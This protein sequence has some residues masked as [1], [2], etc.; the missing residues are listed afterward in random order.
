MKNLIFTLLFLIYI[1]TISHLFAEINLPRVFTNNMVLQR[2]MP[3]NIWGWAEPDE[4]I[5]LTF[6]GKAF[7]TKADASGEW[8][9]K[10]PA[11]AAGGPYEMTIS[12]ENKIH[13]KNILFGDV[14][15]CSG[16]S[17]MYFRVTAAKNAYKDINE[18][19]YKNIRLFQIDKD[20]NYQPKQDLASGEWQECSPQTVR[21][22]SAVAYFFG[23]ELHKRTD[24]PIG[25]IH[26]S[27][28]G[29]VIQAWMDAETIKRFDSYWE[30][31]KE[32]E[33]TPDYFTKLEQ[34]Y[35][36]NG[37]NLLVKAIYKQDPGF[38]ADGSLSVSQFFSEND[39]QDILV[40]GYWEDSELPEYN[41]TVWYRKKI[42]LPDAF[43]S[44]DLLLD[45]GWIDDYDFTFFNGKRIGETFYKG[46]ER[47]YEIPKGL[48]K[49]GINEILVCVYDYGGKGG[50]W[51]P[52]KSHLK[53]KGD[54]SKLQISLQGLW[55]FKSGLDIK[56]LHS[57][58]S[59]K[60]PRKRA[61]PTF[62]YNAMISPL[63]QFGIKGVIWY[64]GE[65]NTGNPGEYARLFPEMISG[66]RR[67]WNQGDFPFLFVQLANYGLPDDKPGQSGWA[68]L[69]EAQL[70]TL[71]LPNT[72][73][74]VAIDLGNA[75]NIHPT[76]KQDVGKRLALPA[77]RIAYGKEVVSSGPIYNSMEIEN[78]KVYI[79]FKHIG[80]G[81][82][83]RDKFGYL[84]EFSIAGAD[85]KFVWA[86]AYIDGD[87]V[88][89]FSDKVRE[90]A[91]VRYGWSA[92]PSQANLYNKEGLP[93][94]PFRT[95]SWSATND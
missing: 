1:G 50:F 70:K 8:A 51:G 29:S 26:A 49:E 85:K 48:I 95:D 86:K 88:V 27:W 94:S 6:F 93:A 14:W 12:G 36:E 7:A 25:L 45:L 52:R 10:L 91:A 41:G 23:R 22:F 37:G 19:N 71:T 20:A 58:K 67:I 28:G 90:P 47:K 92:N 77:L 39:W 18:A 62:L 21:G 57:T 55:Q 40:P 68:E 16:Q 74:A 15:I 83:S 32:I 76:N 63:T 72:G 38:N 89:V 5:M 42:E 30:Q 56:N 64:Q 82:V 65:S 73:M 66:W 33:H 24:V 87:R 11:T 75:M 78:G 2:D 17:N 34:E 80:G 9:V 59:N 60:K 43:Q 69:R 84:K 54:D 3:V 53:I 44:R 46:T 13:L 31:V 61:I 79:R 4:K 35:E 81:L